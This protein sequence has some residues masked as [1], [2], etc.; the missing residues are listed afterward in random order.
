MK[1][2]L[3]ISS[4]QREFAEERRLLA[5]WLRAD[6]I[7]GQFFSPFLF[8]NVPA[9]DASPQGVYL[10][11]VAGCDVY[12]LLAGAEYG[13]EDAEGV[14]PTE[15]EYDRATALHKPRLAFVKRTPER[16]AKE[17]AFLRKVER[18]HVRRSFASFEELRTAVYAALARFLEERE[19]LRILPFDAA[20]DSGAKA[21][22]LDADRMADFLRVARARRGLPLPEGTPP[23][24]LLE[25]LD[26]AD[27]AGRVTNAAVLLFGRRP[28]RFFPASEVKC[29]QFYGTRVEKPMSSLQIYKGDVFQLVDAATD[30][31]MGRIDNWV[32][33]RSSGR[34]AEVPTKF[35]LP[36]E[37]VKEAIVNA[38][39]HRDYTSLA[40][41]QV[42]LFRDRLEIWSPGPLPRGMTVEKLT[43]PHR[44]IPVNP[45]LAQA[46]YL[47]GYV[48]K[49]GTGTEDM[50]DLCRRWG[51]PPPE[52]V[53]DDD[54]KVVLRRPSR[55]ESGKTAIH[56]GAAS[57]SLDE[58]ALKTALETALK[59]AEKRFPES[60][61]AKQLRMLT[62]LCGNPEITLSAIATAIGVSERTAD[63]YAATLREIGI[64]KRIGGRKTG[65]WIVETGFQPD[66][67]S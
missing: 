19:V 18:A 31:V 7:L 5:E 63:V 2:R 32:G 59:T 38:V 57:G 25:H 62:L 65:K 50:A 34:T 3:F 51:L 43:R 60:V 44:S 8:E 47:K 27:D 56:S 24:S 46:M 21:A 52:F 29:C 41:V 64:V 16:A 9:C 11:E 36:Q 13:F 1:F 4:V 12:L 42:M 53:L 30:F 54:F 20:K 15:R 58:A 66:S 33:T 22:D 6:A 67:T 40:S 17:T 39:C 14:S 10:D 45:L 26:L 55:A 35:E 61:F 23:K 49:A 37:A 48:E 28:Q